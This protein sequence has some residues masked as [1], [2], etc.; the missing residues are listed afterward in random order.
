MEYVHVPY[1]AWRYHSTQE[2][3]I[4]ASEEEDKA[5]GPEWHKSPALVKAAPSKKEGGS[6]A[7]L[8]EEL[9][10]TKPAKKVK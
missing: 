4:V 6:L 3:R 1:P 2:A 8:A 9:G 10:A 5:L 7:D